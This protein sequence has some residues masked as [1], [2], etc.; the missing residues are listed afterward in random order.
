MARAH[1]HSAR[2][3]EG[4][5][6]PAAAQSAANFLSCH[7]NSSIQAS[8]TGQTA[9]PGCKSTMIF[10]ISLLLILVHML[11]FSGYLFLT[12]ETVLNHTRIQSQCRSSSKENFYCL[13]NFATFVVCLLSFL[14]FFTL[15]LSCLVFVCYSLFL[16]NL[17]NMNR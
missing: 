6:W 10:V 4:S 7:Q 9:F 3:R 2:V 17:F 15:T 5:G 13:L 11:C 14:V 1:P 16:Q 8:G 12:H